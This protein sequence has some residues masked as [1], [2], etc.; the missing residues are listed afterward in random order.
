MVQ[1]IDTLYNTLGS[2]GFNILTQC[3]FQEKNLF[4]LLDIYVEKGVTRSLTEFNEKLA[5]CKL[6]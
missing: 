2:Y 5:L 6:K 4:Y 1:Y 3:L